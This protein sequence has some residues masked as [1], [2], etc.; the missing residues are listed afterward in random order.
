MAFMQAGVSCRA[1][2]R[3]QMVMSLDNLW[4]IGTA[5]MQARVSCKAVERMQMDMSLDSPVYPSNK[6]SLVQ[7]KPI[8]WVQMQQVAG[9]DKLIPY[10]IIVVASQA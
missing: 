9:S 1:V 3:M 5:F 4:Q 6:V 7:P 8:C 10:I 2:E